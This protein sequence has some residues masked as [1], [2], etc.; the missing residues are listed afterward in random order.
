MIMGKNTLMRKSLLTLQTKPE[1]EDDDYAERMEKWAE[2]PHISIIRDQLKLNIGMIFSNGDLGEIKQILDAN[3]RGAPARVGQIAPDDVVIPPG[4]TGLDPKQTGFFQ[5]L[6]IATKIAKA[7]IEIINP[8]TIIE[9][10][11]KINQS[12]AALLDK[13]KIRP[14]AYKMNVTKFLDGGKLFDAKVLSITPESIL[15]KFKAKSQNLTALSLGSGYIVSSAAPHCV[16]RAFKNLAAVS[17]ASGFEIEQLKAIKAA[18]AA[19]PAT[20]AP[21]GKADAPKK[22]EKVEEEEEDLDMGGMFGD[23]DY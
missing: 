1:E 9:T 12:Q 7:Q 10:G 22:E 5:A 19:G 6:N 20:S 16:A 13:L 3:S 11:Q 15:E 4:P 23:D 17:L 14:F 21:A 18:A 8:V 2:R